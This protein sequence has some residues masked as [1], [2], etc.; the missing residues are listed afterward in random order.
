MFKSLWCEIPMA[1]SEPKIV[2][3]IEKIALRLK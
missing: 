1:I 2:K 3:I